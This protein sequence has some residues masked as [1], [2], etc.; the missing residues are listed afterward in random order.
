MTDNSLFPLPMNLQ[1]QT[2]EEISKMFEHYKLAG[3]MIAKSLSD[4]KLI[5]LPISPLFWELVL[6]KVV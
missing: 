5:D 6:G 3:V 4:D 2:N 1:K